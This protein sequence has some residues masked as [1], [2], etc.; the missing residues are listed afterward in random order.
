MIRVT[1][2]EYLDK[3]QPTWL[4]AEVLGRVH[5]D[6]RLRLVEIREIDVA[7]SFEVRTC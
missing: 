3:R 7:R 6:W 4:D 5:Y 1:P 2:N